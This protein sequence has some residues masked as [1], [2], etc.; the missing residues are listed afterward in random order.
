MVSC[1]SLDFPIFFEE[2]LAQGVGLEMQTQQQPFPVLVHSLLSTNV[3]KKCLPT[4]LTFYNVLQLLHDKLLKC[5]RSTVRFAFDGAIAVF[6][7]WGL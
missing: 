3:R 1:Y 5:D 7:L 6:A 4:H 2:P